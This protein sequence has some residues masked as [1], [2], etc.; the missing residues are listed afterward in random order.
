MS[1]EREAEI[2]AALKNFHQTSEVT[3]LVV[4]LL[5]IRRHRHRDR[6]EKEESDQERGR[7][8]E[9]KDLLQIFD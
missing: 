6:L 3:R 4:E 1:K 8:L 2:K 7:S 9:C 5:N